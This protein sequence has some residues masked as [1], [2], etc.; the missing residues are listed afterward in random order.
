MLCAS[1]PTV[2]S[3]PHSLPSYQLTA[4]AIDYMPVSHHALGNSGGP[5]VQT[6]ALWDMENMIQPIRG[7]DGSSYYESRC[8]NVYK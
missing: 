8:T 5:S 1:S 4:H 3:A 7:F 6:D 2:L